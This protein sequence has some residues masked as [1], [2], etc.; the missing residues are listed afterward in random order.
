MKRLYDNWLDQTADMRDISHEA[1]MARAKAK[2]DLLLSLGRWGTQSSEQQQILALTAQ[3]T[4]VNDN[5]LKISQQLK[6]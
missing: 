2:F 4:K 5:A 3:L 1:L 6:N